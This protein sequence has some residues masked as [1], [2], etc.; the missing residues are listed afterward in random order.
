MGEERGT[1]QEERRGEKNDLFIF[2]TDPVSIKSTKLERV[3][4]LML[5]AT[6][7]KTCLKS[8]A[9]LANTALL[10]LMKH[11]NLATTFNYPTI[12]SGVSVRFT[13]CYVSARK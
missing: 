3:K 8:V 12:H 10:S 2:S 9:L 5:F 7:L 11:L 1:R 6:D 13:S 4:T